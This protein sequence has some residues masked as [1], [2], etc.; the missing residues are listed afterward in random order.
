[1]N[2]VS[3]LIET[4]YGYLIVKVVSFLP[5][6][7]DDAAI[8][9]T[10]LS[11]MKTQYRSRVIEELKGQRMQEEWQRLEAECEI[12]RYDQVWEDYVGKVS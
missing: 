9:E 8:Y 11:D 12:I 6:G 3:Q 1:M 5:S 2:T 7:E 4:E 10:C